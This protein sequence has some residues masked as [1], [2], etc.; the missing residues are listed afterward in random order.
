MNLEQQLRQALERPAD[1]PDEAGAYDRFLRHPGAAPAPC[2]PAP[3]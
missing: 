1:M 2:R 3:A